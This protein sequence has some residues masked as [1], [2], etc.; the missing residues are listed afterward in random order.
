MLLN[1]KIRD[2]AIIDAVELDLQPGFTVV[3]GET[4][5]GKSI[6]VNALG[7]VLGGRASTELIRSGSPSAEVEALFDISDQPIVRARLETRDLVGDD[8][9][10]LLVRRVVG[11]KGK[12]K[13]V[14]NGRLSTV[15]TL[16]E[17]VRGLVDISGQHEQ[18]SLMVVD[19]H[20]EILD[21]FAQVDGLK[22]DFREAYD[23]LHRAQKERN[24]LKYNADEALKRADYLRFQVDEIERL[25]PKEGE[26]DVLE[27]ERTRLSFAERLQS[28]VASAEALLYG[29]DGSA[30]DKLG[31]AVAEI[32]ALVRY[33][34]DLEPVIQGLESAQ[35]EIQEGARTLQRYL[36]RV[37][38]DPERLDTVEGRLGELRRLIRKHGQS[39]TDVFDRHGVLAVELAAIDDSDARIAKLDLQVEQLQARAKEAALALSAGR[40]AAGERLSRAVED[41]LSD[42]ELG[43]AVFSVAMTV[44]CAMG[45]NGNDQ[46]E[47]LWSANRGEPPRPLARIASGGE[48]SRMMLAVKRVLTA[49][50]LVSLYVFDEVD[51]G[52]G[53]RTADTIGRKIQAVAAE[54]Q[55]ITITHL[56]PIAACASHHVTVRKEVHNGRT[57]S[58]IL[59]LE[60]EDRAEEIARMIDGANI[61]NVTRRAA[62]EMLQRSAVLGAG[63]KHLT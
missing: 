12:G 41:E 62:R 14:I 17:I 31:K 16:G 44:E 30:F 18:Q 48:L 3:T 15:A 61:T 54:H 46:V 53:G 38:V 43:G 39:L 7:L 23:A 22:G 13:V 52:L 21:S 24:S 4:G 45:P 42:M 11:T 34:K 32:T 35:R 8:N 26:D 36:T 50:D 25:D 60:A 20:I 28:G 10:V 57:I 33:D 27:A 63:V 49:R 40:Q 59:V 2:F 29:E 55:A 56:A 5:A 6:L 19:N 9:N 51:T 58:T 47:F 37:E 1:L